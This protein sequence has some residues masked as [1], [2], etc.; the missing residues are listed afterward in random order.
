MQP[1][2]LSLIFPISQVFGEHASASTRRSRTD[3]WLSNASLSQIHCQPIHSF[4][5]NTTF[6]HPH[7]G[8]H[9]TIAMDFLSSSPLADE[10]VLHELGYD[11][12]GSD[13]NMSLPQ[14]RYTT[15]PST[16]M[17]DTFNLVR[18]TSNS[19]SSELQY[20]GPSLNAPPGREGETPYKDL[21]DFESAE[22]ILD[23]YNNQIDTETLFT[24][25]QESVHWRSQQVV[26]NKP[27]YDETIP[28]E[29][30]KKQA[31][32]KLL[33]KAWKSVACATDNPG[34]KKPFEE[35]RHDNARVEC[36]CWMLLEA[37]IRR[38][39]SGPLLVSY[40]P[41]KT[42][43]NP[44]I[45]SFAMRLDEVVISLREQKTICKHLLDAPY[46]NTF[47]DD[48]VRARNRVAS[49]RDL[50]KKKGDTMSLGKGLLSRVSDRG[51][52]RTKGKK[53]A[54]SLSMDESISDEL[55]LKYSPSPPAIYGTPRQT[56]YHSR[57]RKTGGRTSSQYTLT[58][59]RSPYGNSGLYSGS[60]V[61]LHMHAQIPPISHPTSPAPAASLSRQTTQSSS[62]L[63]V[64]LSPSS[65]LMDLPQSMFGNYNQTMGQNMN[66]YIVS[67][68]DLARPTLLGVGGQVSAM[69]QNERILKLLTKT[70][71]PFPSQPSGSTSNSHF[72]PTSAP[73][74]TFTHPSQLEN[75]NFASL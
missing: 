71:F 12:Y 52:T 48:P 58:S 20:W 4:C 28:R 64:E 61:G 26:E 73:R 6:G 67:P 22:E 11:V 15:V 70:Q 34:M 53:R 13:R 55:S 44:A 65:T 41:T 18:S 16:A 60:P 69:N 36:V 59:M 19:G 72:S 57:S 7:D 54:R 62:S 74:Q 45:T 51:S 10:S 42:K 66:G 8:S 17:N 9:K 27:E 2:I 47:V 14:N 50:N 46:I 29:L 30:H 38:S 32:V 43:E 31:C 56:A 1:V 75:E 49:N 35:E 24:S 5:F 63:S 3:L 25:L 33:F 37:L 39:E 68:L 40:D 21:S 23:P